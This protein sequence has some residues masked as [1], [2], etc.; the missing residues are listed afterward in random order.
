[1]EFRPHISALSWFPIGSL[2]TALCLAVAMGA[3]VEEAPRSP[4][5][6]LSA[7]VKNNVM[8]IATGDD[9]CSS[10]CNEHSAV[11]T[12]MWI[13][14]TTYFSTPAV[15]MERPYGDNAVVLGLDRER[16]RTQVARGDRNERFPCTLR[17]RDG[18]QKSEYIT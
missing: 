4:A 7:A 13:V 6:V 12:P 10:A 5:A 1:M 3:I 9:A 2:R 17:L 11:E 14:F 18:R 16:P 15:Q 8:A